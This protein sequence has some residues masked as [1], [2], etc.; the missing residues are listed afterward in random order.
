[1]EKE[2]SEN[3]KILYKPTNSLRKRTNHSEVQFN[4][5]RHPHSRPATVKNDKITREEKAKRHKDCRNDN[6]EYYQVCNPLYNKTEVEKIIRPNMLHRQKANPTGT[7]L[8]D[9]QQLTG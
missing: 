9:D 3:S 6:G 4:K 2:N 5:A 1:M 7:T 8:G